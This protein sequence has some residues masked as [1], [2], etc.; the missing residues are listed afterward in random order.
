[1][2]NWKFWDW[3]AYTCLGVAA[4]GMAVGES[5]KEN[6]AMFEWL[7]SFLLSPKLAYAPIILFAL[8]SAIL[9]VRVIVPIVAQPPAKPSIISDRVVVDVTP[10]YLLSLGEGRTSVERDRIT[11]IYFNKWLKVSGPVRNVNAIGHNTIIVS[12]TMDY[13]KEISLRFNAQWYDRVA[14]LR[15]GQN[16]AAIGQIKEIYQTEI[17]LENCELTELVSE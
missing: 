15:I 17:D 10:Q 6:Q 13:M 12:V 2:R 7:P 1:M 8:G 14:I 11:G 3:I 5:L 9:A 4:I 16:I